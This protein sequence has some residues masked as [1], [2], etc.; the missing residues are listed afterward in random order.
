MSIG[1]P[2]GSQVIS[3]EF[4]RRRL[5]T[6]ETP[7]PGAEMK[8]VTQARSQ[9]SGE[10]PSGSWISPQ[11]LVTGARRHGPSFFNNACVPIYILYRFVHLRPDLS[12]GILTFSPNPEARLGKLKWF[13]GVGDKIGWIAREGKRLRGCARVIWNRIRRGFLLGTIRFNI[14]F[15][16]WVK[17]TYKLLNIVE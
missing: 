6:R 13:V 17:K 3:I 1:R 14:S 5:L 15:F 4:E 16:F 8:L 7:D 11:F 2:Q 9:E 10:I 12:T